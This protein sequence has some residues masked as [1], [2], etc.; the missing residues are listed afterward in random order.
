MLTKLISLYLFVGVLLLCFLFVNSFVR[1]R[2]RYAKVLGA[3]SLSLQVYL[4]GYMVEINTDTLQDMLFWNQVQYLGIP[5]FPGLWLAVSMLYTDRGKYMRGFRSLFI[6]TIPLITFFMRLT[7]EWHHLY[8][9]KI[10]LQTIGDAELMFLSKGPWYLVQMVYVLITLILC[11]S[12]YYER[13]KRSK[14]NERIQFSLLLLA[15]TM[16]YIAL[17]MV[18]TNLGGIGIDYTAL[19]LP[20]CIILIN[21]ALTRYNFLEI[22]V[23][24]RERVFEDSASGLL[25]LNRYNSIVDYNQ[26]SLDYLKWLGIEFDEGKLEKV[27]LDS[28]PLFECIKSEKETIFE[29]T[30]EGAEK[31]LLCQVR[32]IENNDQDMGKLIT[33]EDVTE[34]KILEKQLVKMANIDELSGLNNR[35]SFRKLALN[36]YE[37]ALIKEKPLSV[38]MMDLDYFKRINDSF[39][40]QAGDHVIK[41]FSNLMI[42]TFESYG[43]SGRMGGEEFAVVLANTS[44]EEAMDLAEHFRKRVEEEVMLFDTTAIKVTVSIGISASSKDQVL[45][46]DS[47][48]SKADNGLYAAKSK[49]RNCSVFM[50]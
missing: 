19:I 47:L 1:G 21:L 4:L 16:P 9:S 38:L 31:Y 2:T 8:Y 36:L 30:W 34:R 20:P 42:K 26:S 46:Y 23:L 7:N 11:T 28:P 12:F 39:G 35:R 40:H 18:T 6:F 13:Y 45:N 3:L 32:G 27:A 33:F 24:A 15:S 49:G 29:L 50:D 17:I 14:G 5:F 25:I 41:T 10:E 44:K 37:E 43:V 22:R 48:F